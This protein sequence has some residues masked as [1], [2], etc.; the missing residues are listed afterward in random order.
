[1][2]HYKARIYSPT[3][4]RFMQTDPI[5]YEDQF[6]LYTYVGNDPVNNVDPTG[7]ELRVRGTP[8]DTKT[9]L[10]VTQRATGMPFSVENNRMV[11]GASLRQNAGLAAITMV[12]GIQATDSVTLT[13]VNQ[14]PI[15]YDAFNLPDRPIDVGDL[16]AALDHDQNFGA[17]MLTHVVSERTYAVANQTS[18]LPAHGYA[19]GQEAAVM[20][21]VGKQ[22][23]TSASPP[24]QPVPGDTLT[25]TYTDANQAPVTSHTLTYDNRLTPR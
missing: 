25:F 6:N 22:E 7:R 13:F 24:W 4:G 14:S 2:Y 19:T 12:N 21:A 3:L 15:I 1:M 16:S 8:D 11:V 5:G 10:Q 23:S 17:A 9:F 20:G 18:Y